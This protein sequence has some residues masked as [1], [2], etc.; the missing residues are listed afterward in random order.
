MAECLV[1]ETGHDSDATWLIQILTE[2][3][4]NITKALG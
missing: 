3:Q 2:W 1:I 4:H